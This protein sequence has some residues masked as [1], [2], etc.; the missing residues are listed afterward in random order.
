MPLRKHGCNPWSQLVGGVWVF[1]QLDASLPDREKIT[2][3]IRFTIGFDL[4]L[5]RTRGRHRLWELF[6]R[7][8]DEESA[9]IY[10]EQAVWPQGPVCPR[11]ESGAHVGS[12]SDPYRCNACDRQFTVRIGTIFE[13]SHIQLHHWLWAI[14]ILASARR[15]VSSTK[16]AALLNSQ[17]TVSFKIS[18]PAVC[19]MI[20]KLR[21]IWRDL[22]DDSSKFLDRD[23]LDFVEFTTWKWP[24]FSERARLN[25]TERGSELP[26]DAFSLTPE[27]VLV[28]FGDTRSHEQRAADGAVWR[29]KEEAQKAEDWERKKKRGGP[30]MKG[31]LRYLEC[32]RERTEA[33]SLDHRR[34]IPFKWMPQRDCPMC[35]FGE[36]EWRHWEA[37]AVRLDLVLWEEIWD[38]REDL[39]LAFKDREDSARY[40][41]EHGLDDSVYWEDFRREW[42]ATFIER[43][44]SLDDRVKLRYERFW[45]YADKLAR[46]RMKEERR[47][48]R[49]QEWERDKLTRL[50]EGEIIL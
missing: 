47:V 50:A 36:R 30:R 2:R 11:C 40:A 32:L 37:I 35:R 29:A 16:L 28:G 45:K 13:G 48:L 12:G 26:A 4:Q 27:D 9:R 39:D 44:R 46:N 19:G 8:P 14:I 17:P 41:K 34:Q 3:I 15:R 23:Y 18:Q 43:W 20:R 5:E 10:I 31:L 21:P 25:Y 49:E 42:D 33:H 38:W 6:V 1:D 22:T 24:F 7:F